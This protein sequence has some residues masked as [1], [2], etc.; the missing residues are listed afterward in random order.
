MQ[1]FERVLMEYIRQLDSNKNLFNYETTIDDSE[2]NLISQLGLFPEVVSQAYQKLS[3]NSIANYAYQ[4]AKFFNE[5]YHSSKVIG[6]EKEKF[7]LVLV[8]SFAQVL[9]NSLYLLGINVI[10][11]M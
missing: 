3:P 8:D 7:R 9:K 6:S 10:E 11:R 5:F 1:P 4:I 2:K